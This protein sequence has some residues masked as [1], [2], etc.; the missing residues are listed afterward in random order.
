M[1]VQIPRGDMTP[2]LE[3][4]LRR[5]VPRIY[6]IDNWGVGYFGVNSRGHLV[7]KP[8]RGEREID[9]LEVVQELEKRG[10]QSPLL[11]RFPQIL[12]QQ[13]A[14]LKGAFDRAI[15]EFDY[16]KTYQ[17][18]Y[19]MKVNPRREVVE[20]LVTAG[21]P[22][23]LGLEVGSK[24]ELY[25]AL[26]QEPHPDSLLICNGFKDDEFMEMAFWAHQ[27]GRRVVIVLEQV[28]EVYS[29]M[30]AAE[31]NEE[32]P[33]LGMRGKLYTRGSGKWEDS[34]GETSKFGLSTIEMLE[35]IRLL[36]EEGY[37]DNLAML[38]FHIGSQITDIRKI[39]AAVREA[40]RV[41]AKMKSLGVPIQFLN[42]GGGL[43]IDYD[44]SGSSSDSSVNYTAQEFANDVVYT[45]GDIC[46]NEE[47]EPPILVS[48]SGRAL[49]VYHSILILSAESR[50][51]PNL[52]ARYEF[53]PKKKSP[54]LA[55]MHDILE[56]INVKNYR[57][58]YHDA[59]QRRDE[60]FSLFDL[61]YLGLAERAQAEL[62]FQ[63]VCEKA[64]HFAML[65]KNRSEDFV[66]LAKALR[67]KYVSNFSVFQSLPDSWTIGQLFPILPIHR[68]DEPP[69]EYG[70]LADLSCDS[71]GKVD[72]FVDIKT[73]KDFVE[74][75]AVLPGEPYYLAICMVGA[76][77]EVMGSFH[78][79]F[80]RV[81]EAQLLVDDDGKVRIEG[82]HA[83]HRIR[84]VVHL[85]G[86]DADQL[87]SRLQA[88]IEAQVEAGELLREDADLI[89]SGVDKCAA[90]ST[91]LR[92]HRNIPQEEEPQNP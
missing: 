57:E 26:T 29:Y 80:G 64:L 53:D 46:R 8:D 55:E 19:P 72:S 27:L 49:S 58:Y 76:Y 83:G 52:E 4:A 70:I 54:A 86:Y 17:G 51:D 67:K 63:E 45:V 3:T 12:D 91:Y 5:S 60:L 30:R 42:V 35:C 61:G 87:R 89:L 47:V 48:E 69:T 39:K 92:D 88:R 7:V 79:L 82:L 43:G 22:H 9:L 85:V 18:V 59:L 66:L 24:P 13:V 38:H 31:R 21:R 20:R 90:R 62:L 50:F 33:L 84:D 14:N 37:E 25:L 34:G 15:Q 77:Q 23:K 41:Y 71:D 1:N 28:K 6:G 16:P 2:S 81:N 10:M 65:T 44:G 32:R 36:R 68:L 73:I 11:L 56:E 78:N 40:S 74:L 75:H